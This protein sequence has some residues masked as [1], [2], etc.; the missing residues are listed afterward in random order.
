MLLAWGSSS[1]A[2]AYA[3]VAPKSATAEAASSAYEVEAGRQ[4]FLIGCASCHGKNADGHRDR[5]R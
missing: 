4:L 1:P 3:T 5:Q 2:A